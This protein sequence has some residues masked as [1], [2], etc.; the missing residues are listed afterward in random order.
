MAAP[1]KTKPLNAFYGVHTTVISE[2]CGVSTRTDRAYKNGTR[3]PSKAVR[4]LFALHRDGRVFGPTWTGWTVK[5]ESLVDPDGN[6]TSRQ[7]LHHYAMVM[8]FARQMAR[9][10]SAG[11]HR[12]FYKLLS[13]PPA[14]LRQGG[15]SHAKPSGPKG[16]PR[17]RGARAEGVTVAQAGHGRPAPQK[18]QDVARAPARLTHL[19][20]LRQPTHARQDTRGLVAELPAPQVPSATVVSEGKNAWGLSYSAQGAQTAST[21]RENP[22][23]PASPLPPESVPLA[24]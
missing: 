3:K 2:W 18:R 17:A 14:A 24:P 20:P 5:P 19:I 9:E 1:T 16:Q 12:E 4:R 23:S 15:A 11:K 21:Q 22:A 7:L 8:Q 10:H 13:P 6:E